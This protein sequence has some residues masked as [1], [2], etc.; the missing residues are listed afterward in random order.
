M[1][2]GI[3][4]MNVVIAVFLQSF[5]TAMESAE[6]KSRE[7][8]A[9]QQQ[10]RVAGPLDRLLEG[11]GNFTSA[12][13]LHNQIVSLFTLLDEDNTGSL[14]CDEIREG[15]GRNYSILGLQEPIVRMPHQPRSSPTPR[16]VVGC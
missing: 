2:V 3:V 14:S 5:L 8:F 15:L 13:H 6:M 16:F 9:S 4:S 11:L 1:I 10:F 7:V 12:V